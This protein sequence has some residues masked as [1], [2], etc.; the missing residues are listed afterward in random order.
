MPL[1]TYVAR[2]TKGKPERGSA[3]GVSAAE[4]VSQL[5][6]RGLIVLDVKQADEGQAD[7]LPSRFHI[8]QWIPPSS[9]D[10]EI[11]LQQL[12]IMLRNGLTLLNSLR[13]LIEQTGKPTMRRLWQRVAQRIQQGMT[14]ADAMEE[15]NCFPPM[16]IEMTRVGEQTGA[17]DAVLGRAAESL[18]NKR[19]LKGNLIGALAYPVM[20]LVLTIGVTAAMVY[21]LIPRL[22]KLLKA[23]G[24]PLPPST[25]FLLDVSNAARDYLPQILLVLAIL[26]VAL[27]FVIKWPPG[28]LWI[29]RILL[30]VPIVGNIL[31]LAGTIMF[32][33]SLG[34]LTKSGIRLLEA[35]RTVE[36]LI[37][38]R[39]LSRTVANARL[40][41]MQGA[42]LADPLSVKFTFTPMLS[43]MVAVGEKAGTL[44]EVLE[45]VAR[46]HE[47]QLRTMIK[48]FSAA[49]EP[50]MIVIVGSIVGFVYISVFSALYSWQ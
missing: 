21:F 49:I 44:D 23:M 8:L 38:N 29:D 30:R 14:L 39:H 28:R 47:T 35:L 43:R 50:V 24:R 15:H 10:I 19:E 1:Y 42:S 37:F 12:A 9:K 16:V 31:R 20:I 5:R 3:D 41:V 22:E 34:T 33:R 32:A 11:S 45:E 4:V 17:L 36:P 25:Q 2:D 26:I 48:R 7:A 13:T 18:A 27:I 40:R 6:E 46:F